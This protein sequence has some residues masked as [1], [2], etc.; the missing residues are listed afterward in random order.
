MK[1]EKILMLMMVCSVLIASSMN[2]AAVEES[3]ILDDGLPGDVFDYGTYELVTESQYIDVDNI[4]ISQ[5]E[6]TITN[7]TI[8]FTMTV[9]GVIEDRGS[10][11]EIESAAVFMQTE[12]GVNVTVT[13][14]DSS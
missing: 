7:E 6:Y 5:V 13:V 10:L 1:I 2:V 9:V 14:H 8:E 11:E 4:D 3:G 12:P